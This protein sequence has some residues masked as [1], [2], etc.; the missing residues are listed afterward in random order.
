[1]LAD[2]PPKQVEPRDRVLTDDK[3]AAVMNI[4]GSAWYTMLQ[5]ILLTGIRGGEVCN[6]RWEELDL[7]R[8]AR[9][10]LRSTMKQ[11]KPHAVPLSNA[12]R[13]IIKLQ[14]EQN[15]GGWGPYVFSLGSRG[16][17]PFNGRSTGI[18]GVRR[19]TETTDRAGHDCRQ[20]SNA[21]RQRIG[22]PRGVR[23]RITEHA[24]LGDG[25]SAYE[26][27]D[28]RM[29]TQEAVEKLAD[30]LERIRQAKPAA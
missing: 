16:E 13:K 15:S 24:L 19:L 25:A 9:N 2:Q 17:R 12:A 28:F 1:M 30:G 18:E 10:V 29:K 14:L 8:G 6:I 21:F 20:T 5:F 22:I 3:L 11:G 26:H 23:L 27:H 7:G 4:Q